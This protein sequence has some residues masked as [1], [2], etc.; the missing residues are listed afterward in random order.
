MVDLANYDTGNPFAIGAGTSI[1]VATGDAIYGDDTEAWTLVNAGDV[2]SGVDG[3]HLAHGGSVT[4]SGAAS[5]ITGGASGVVIE[6]GF[7]T[8]INGG[9]IAASEFYGVALL[10]GGG[11]DNSGVIVGGK[12]EVVHVGG[13][14]SPYSGGTG[15]YLG[16]GG[17][18][19]NTGTITEG[20]GRPGIFLKAGG[21]VVNEGTHALI[22]NGVVSGGAGVITNTGTISSTASG[23][24]G[25]LILEGG[26]VNN[27]APAA[28]IT[29]AGGV[30]IRGH[31]GEVNNSGSISANGMF[32]PRILLGAGGRVTNW[33]A[34][35]RPNRNLHRRRLGCPEECGDN[36]GFGESRGVRRYPGHGRRGE[37]RGRRRPDRWR[38]WRQHRRDRRNDLEFGDH[39]GI[40]P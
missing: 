30:A 19:T 20:E 3:V 10:A 23:G 32:S 5:R 14:T 8:V 27:G 7:G 39:L 15:V 38:G 31:A 16:R 18:V 37:Q 22:I 13:T 26:R 12:L 24:I 33:R 2:R 9:T 35:H 29:G 28:L 4:N 34:H 11:I 40:K 36:Q 17:E 21:A 1:I 6:G 25:V